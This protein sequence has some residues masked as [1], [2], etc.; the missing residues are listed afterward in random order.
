MP[1]SG[2]SN[3]LHKK[4]SKDGANVRW[5][6]DQKQGCAEKW[7]RA[8]W[9]TGLRSPRLTAGAALCARPFQQGLL[10]DPNRFHNC[11]QHPEPGAVQQQFLTR[12]PKPRA[13][14]P[15][16]SQYRQYRT[17]RVAS[18]RPDAR[19]LPARAVAQRRMKDRRICF[20][21]GYAGA[22]TAKHLAHTLTFL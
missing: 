14:G 3:R 17:G 1:R 7:V 2:T 21:L 8:K 20:Y 10:Y 11:R 9:R 5:R 22:Q 12:T 18:A 16:A 15:K 4:S 13:P 19:C 6:T